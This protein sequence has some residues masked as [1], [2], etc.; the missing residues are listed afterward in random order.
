MGSPRRRQ[1]QHTSRCESLAKS[2]EIAPNRT[3]FVTRS[4]PPLFPCNI[5]HKNVTTHSLWCDKPTAN[6]RTSEIQTTCAQH[7]IRP[8][9]NATPVNDKNKPNTP[10]TI[11]TVHSNPV[12]SPT[13]KHHSMKTKNI[14][15]TGI[16]AL[17]SLAVLTPAAN[18]VFTYNDGDIVVAF[19]GQAATPHTGNTYLVNLGNA[20]L[21]QTSGLYATGNLVTINTPT[22]ANFLTDLGTASISLS[23]GVY[24]LFGTDGASVFMSRAESTAGTASTAIANQ[25]LDAPV[26]DIYNV[27]YAASGT[28]ANPDGLIQGTGAPSSYASFM[29]GSNSATQ[30]FEG[31][32][33]NP[34]GSLTPGKVMDLYQVNS[35]GGSATRLGAFDFNTATGAMRFSSDVSDF[36]V[37]AVPEPASAGILTAAFLGI[38]SIGKRRRLARAAQA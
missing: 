19:S 23:N 2:A 16:L 32:F 21:F 24:G 4:T 30:A 3:H 18:A 1:I 38:V 33:G 6:L 10:Q 12:Q 26:S 9:A 14:L 25:N 27:V 11:A 8:D 37:V 29:F 5:R 7:C 31:N 35:G 36:A 28:A 13:H 20:S 15:T 17:A 22:M 34:E